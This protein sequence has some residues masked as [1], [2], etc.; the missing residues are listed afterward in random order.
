MHTAGPIA[1]SSSHPDLLGV[2]PVGREDDVAGEGPVRVDDRD[3]ADLRF[4]EL[5]CIRLVRS[6]HRRRTQTSSGST[7]SGAKTM[8]LVKVQ[9]GSTTEMTLI[10]ASSNWNAYGWARLW[11]ACAEKRAFMPIAGFARFENIDDV[12][13]VANAGIAS[14]TAHSHGDMRGLMR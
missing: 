8:L 4:V 1:T 10:S 5:A 2:D 6:Q 13:P 12:W 9:Y 11:A 7:P 14:S 3:D